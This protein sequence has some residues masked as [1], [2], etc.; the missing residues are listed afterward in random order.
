MCERLVTPP[1]VVQGEHCVRPRLR[2]VA[3]VAHCASP[4]HL[5]PRTCPLEINRHT[6]PSHFR[7]KSLK[8]NVRTPREVS[9]FFLGQFQ[10]SALVHPAHIALRVLAFRSMLTLFAEV[11]PR[12]QAGA[13]SS[14]PTNTKM[15]RSTEENRVDAKASPA[16]KAGR[17]DR[18]RQH[19]QDRSAERPLLRR[20]DGALADPLRHRHGQNAARVDSRVR[21]PEE[22]RGAGQPG[23]RQTFRR[24]SAS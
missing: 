5:I 18:I 20:A 3:A 19:G 13:A 9:H 7:S 1:R 24:K 21:N 17:S 15:G 23:P 2:R 22:G 6:M 4:S 8:T 12:E 14:A 10:H 16:S 11:A